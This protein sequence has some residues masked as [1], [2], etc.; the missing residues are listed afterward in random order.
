VKFV[1]DAVAC[2]TVIFEPPGFVRVTACIWLVPMVT[3]LKLIV[4]GL[5]VSCPPPANAVEDRAEIAKNKQRPKDPKGML[6]FE[7]RFLTARP[8][9]A[10]PELRGWGDRNRCVPNGAS[11]FS[12]HGDFS[13]QRIDD[14]S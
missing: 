12:E 8:Q 4:E 3:P 2:D 11:L 14:G 5:N 10:V 1:P 9:K 13:V 6:F 7:P